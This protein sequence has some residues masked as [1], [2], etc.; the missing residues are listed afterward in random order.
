MQ[1][2]YKVCVCKGVVPILWVSTNLKVSSQHTLT[3]VLL[4]GRVTKALAH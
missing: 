4:I 2:K 3:L 1:V